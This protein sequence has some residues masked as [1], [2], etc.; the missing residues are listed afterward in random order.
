ML[1]VRVAGAVVAWALGVALVIVFEATLTRGHAQ[2]SLVLVVACL[3][4][5]LGAF[6]GTVVW[7]ASRLHPFRAL[8]VLLLL[9]VAFIVAA[10]IGGSGTRG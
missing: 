7:R 6:T 1:P 4:L 5:C 10:V 9:V 8:A 2:A 3:A